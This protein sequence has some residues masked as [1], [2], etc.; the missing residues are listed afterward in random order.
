MTRL[1]TTIVFTISAFFLSSPVFANVPDD[2]RKAF[3]IY[4]K[5]EAEGNMERALKAAHTAWKLAETQSGDTKLTGD[6]AFNYA[7]QSNPEKEKDQVE[8]AL[9]SMELVDD[10]GADAPLVYLE[11]GLLHVTLLKK[12][13]QDFKAMRAAEGLVEYADANGLGNSTFTAEALT[14]AA[15]VHGNRGNN[16]KAAEAAE[17][18]LKI[19]E[20]STD[21]VASAYS[22]HANLYRGYA[23]EGKED[24]MQAALSYQEVMEMTDGLDPAEFSVV[25]MALGRWIYMRSALSNQDR[26]EEAEQN[27]LCQCWPYD[28]PRNESVQPIKR[29]SPDMPREAAQSGYVVVEFDLTDEGEVTNHKVIT[30]WPDY[31]EEPALDALR[32]WEY[33][34]RTPEETDEDRKGLITTIRFILLDSSGNNLW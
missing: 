9:R 8:A 5:A 18:A 17:R 28:K 25:G 15:G 21:G 6:L 30:A 27:G 34:P 22:I 10:Y 31:Y 7:V 12:L 19:F 13:S 4:K 11:R 20:A 3:N 29:A 2:V 26:L 32:K 14:I 33:S 24:H 23:Y 1:I 16:Q